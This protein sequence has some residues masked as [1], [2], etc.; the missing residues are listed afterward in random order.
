MN[1]TILI[2]GS[3]RGI[4]AA[5][6]VLAAKNGYNVCVNYLKNK[7][8]AQTVVAQIKDLG[9]KAIIVKADV[10]QEEDVIRLFKSCDQLGQL[11]A[12]VNNAGITAAMSR[13]E[14]MSGQ[15]IR[16]IFET[17]VLGN[18]LCAREAIKRM[19][20]KHGGQ[21]GGIVN[22]SSVASKTGSPNVYIDYAASK[23]A[24]DTMTLG[25]AKE[26]T[27]DKIRVNAVRSGFV[28]TDI[29]LTSG[30]PNRVENVKHLIPMKR[31]GKA[32]EIAASVLWLLSKEASYVTGALLDVAGGL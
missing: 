25:L 29:H 8:A 13:L 3:S 26:L 31:G 32:Q 22:I 28:N 30:N 17:N 7:T 23:A 12:L 19:S 18:F 1:P 2:T 16:K 21:G 27:D 14:D 9:Q 5:I 24:I 11:T 6:A 10:S 4:G 20:V 15:R